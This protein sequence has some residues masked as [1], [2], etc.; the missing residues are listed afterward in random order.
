MYGITS[1]NKGVIGSCAVRLFELNAAATG[2]NERTAKAN[3]IPCDSV[4]T[5]SMDK[6]GLMPGSAPMHFKLVF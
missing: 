6:V 3:N 2:L 1:R 4:Y 5:M